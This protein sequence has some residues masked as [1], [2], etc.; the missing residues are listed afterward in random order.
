[1][2]IDQFEDQSADESSRNE[3][4][5]SVLQRVRLERGL[6]E[7]AIADH[8]H[9][10]VHYVKAIECDK[11]EKLPGIVFARGYLKSYAKMLGL[12]PEE[13]LVSFSAFQEGQQKG[14]NP[15]QL[16]TPKAARNRNAYWLAGSVL[17]GVVLLAAGFFLATSEEGSAQNPVVSE[18]VRGAE[19]EVSEPAVPSQQQPALSPAPGLQRAVAAGTDPVEPEPESPQESSQDASSDVL[20]E[21]AVQQTDAVPPATG[22][23]QLEESD[24]VAETQVG[25]AAVEAPVVDDS[26]TRQAASVA[27]PADAAT[28]AGNEEIAAADEASAGNEEQRPEE[29]TDIQVLEGDDGQRVIAVNAQGEDLLRISFSGESWVEVNDGEDRQIYRDLREPGDILEI[30]GHAPFNILLGDAPYTTL[31]FNGADIDV[32]DNIRIDNSARLTVGL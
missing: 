16:R 17:G 32:S 5:G 24:G 12:S 31:N 8:L 15:E 3:S 13:I 10:T 25:D 18:S 11:Y 6:D 4:P 19:L 21:Q 14:N 26:L 29:L 7:K 1:M 23:P 22:E 28:A 27:E 30:S 9:I 20:L 2:P